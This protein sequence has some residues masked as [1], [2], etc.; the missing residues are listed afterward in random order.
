MSRV[1]AVTGKGGTGK[2]ALVVLMTKI[3][4]RDRDLKILVIDAD[5]AIG[6]P[7]A[8]GMHIDKRVSDLRQE[9][10]ED[11]E[12]RQRIAKTH[13]RNV[14]KSIVKQE[15]GLNLLVMGRP[16]GAGCF[17]RVNDLLRYGIESF[18]KDFEVTLIDCEAGPE[19]INRRVIESVDTLIILTDTSS[20][21]VQTADSI[22]EI[23]QAGAISGNSSIGLV[24][25]RLENE[26]DVIVKKAQQLNLQIL[27]HIPEDKNIKE[28]DLLGKPIFKLPD[29][30]P[31]VIAAE[32]IVKELGL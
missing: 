4:T 9:V 7:Q 18:S 13:I 31:S 24:I 12:A 6:L 10:I 3:L 22:R 23:A 11:P 1:I 2:T 28:Y 29:D 26:N 15:D 19:Q 17:C 21:S 27:G 25:N 32:K 8:L 5:S 30:S 14:I 16:E 20:R